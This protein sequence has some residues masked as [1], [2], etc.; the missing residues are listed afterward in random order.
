MKQPGQL[1]AFT[2]N[3]ADY[4]KSSDAQHR[5]TQELMGKIRLSGREHV[6]D[7]GCGDGRVTAE[8]ARNLSEGTVTGADSSPDMIRFA[9]DHFPPEQY[10]N[11]LFVQA[12]ARVL[13]FS[14]EFDVIFSNSALHWMSDQKPVIE[15]IARSLRPGGRMLVQMGGKGNA[16]PVFGVVEGLMEKPRWKRY[17]DDFSFT[18]GFFGSDEYRQWLEEAGFEKVRVDLIPKDTKLASRQDFEGLIRTTWLPWM[19]RLPDKERPVFLGELTDEYIRVY[20][21]PADGMIH[22]P[23][24]RLRAEA[25]KQE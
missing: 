11:L 15:G 17:F 10:P 22:V 3:P 12:D 21:V 5:W 24:V 19:E 6:L 20:P 25:Q 14:G 16:E 13:P 2:W 1:P 8:I 23:M 4:R 18:Y 7:I 9:R